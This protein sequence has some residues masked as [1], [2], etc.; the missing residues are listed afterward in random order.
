[1]QPDV[2]GKLEY[3]RLVHWPRQHGDIRKENIVPSSKRAHEWHSPWGK[4]APTV[5]TNTGCWIRTFQRHCFLEEDVAGALITTIATRPRC[6]G[7][8]GAEVAF[9][10]PYPDQRWYIQ[11]IR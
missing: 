2:Q 8:N 11:A 10:K 6:P 9:R 5:T 7:G 1:M 4:T 3:S